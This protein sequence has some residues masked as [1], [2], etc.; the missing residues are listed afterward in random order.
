M[1]LSLLTYNTLGTPFFAKDITSRYREIAKTINEST[2]DIVCLQEIF[3]HYNHFLM[4]KWLTNFPYRVNK[5]SPLGLYGGLAIYSKLPIEFVK[6][7]I[8]TYP[9]GMSIPFYTKLAQSGI[10]VA[11]LKDIPLT[12]A[13]THLT[14][15]T[16]HDLTPKNKY[17]QLIQNQIFQAAEIF[18]DSENSVILTGDFN[19][20]KGS[21]LYKDFL[22]ATQ[23]KDVFAD[24]D[25][26]TYSP[27]RTPYRFPA[28][29]PSRIDYIFMKENNLKIK[30]ENLI[31]MFEEQAKLQ[32]GKTSYL[33]DHIG[34][35][36]TLH[37]I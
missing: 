37:L 2:L 10:L 25:K 14:T 6:F 24:T 35:A 1:R 21:M 13:T 5:P 3:S 18:K 28:E 4:D 19:T 33:S 27:Q 23:A 32:S 29:N 8:Y 17:F 30:P 26:H 22:R 11:K 16:V 12:L 9:E 31:H 15:D 36:T 34:I 20:N 7:H